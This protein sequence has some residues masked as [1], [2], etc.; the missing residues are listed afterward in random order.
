MLHVC[1]LG[2]HAAL[3][4]STT[5]ASQSIIHI[6]EVNIVKGLEGHNW[7]NVDKFGP[8]RDRE[9]SSMT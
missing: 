5:K 3:D 4:Y 9:I 6:A 2:V 7:S 1:Y 8:N